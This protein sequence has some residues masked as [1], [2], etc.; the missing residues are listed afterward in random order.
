MAVYT[1]VSENEVTEWLKAYDVGGFRALTGIKSG[2]SNS[3]Y[4]LE[5]TKDRYILTLYE[6]RTKAD[7]LPFFLGL[8]EYLAKKGVLCPL[9]IR[10]VDGA[11]MH[12]VAGRPAAIISFLRGKSLPRV[13][14][15]HCAELG[16]ALAT[17]HAAVTDFPMHRPNALSLAGWQELFDACDGRADEVSHGLAALI[18]DEMA[19][20]KEHWPQD[21]P[22]GVIHAD[23]FPDNV[24]FDGA[25]LCGI[26]DL[27]FACNDFLAYDLAICL[28]AWCFEG[29]NMSFNITKARA[30][31]AA[32]QAVRPLS[33]AEKKALPVLARG[34][35]IRFMMTRLY[36]WLNQVPGALVKAKDPLE[37]VARLKFHQKVTDG[38]S[39][40]VEI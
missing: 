10:G 3:N 17:M 9:P 6:A 33:L 21:L 11:A 13:D 15:N 2:V 5:T 20:L 32:Y 35:A 27:Y 4:V 40:G 7:D 39:Y 14:P 8:M 16:H 24:L 25:K 36:D 19:F 18:N 26:I 31:L 22:A 12:P 1:N 30:M 23:L 29:N 37:Y 28:N 34:A 38:S